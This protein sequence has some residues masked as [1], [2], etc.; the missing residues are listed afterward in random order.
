M[1]TEY[2]ENLLKWLTQRFEPVEEIEPGNPPVFLSSETHTNNLLDYIE[3]YTT[4]N[5]FDIV[6][7]KVIPAKDIKGFTTGNY[8]LFLT[9]Y[10]KSVLILTD[11]LYNPIQTIDTMISNGTEVDIPDL[12]DAIEDDNGNIIAIQRSTPKVLFFNNPYVKSLNQSNY[13]LIR[14][15]TYTI[16]N[17]FGVYIGYGVE[18]HKAIGRS[19]YA[20]VGTDNS[21]N[22]KI[23]ELKINVGT[24]DELTVYS[25]TVPTAYRAEPGQS[26]VYWD[27]EDKLNATIPYVVILGTG[28]IGDKVKYSEYTTVSDS[29]TLSYSVKAEL[30][31]LSA[32]RIDG[33]SIVY[34]S[35]I[36]QYVYLATYTNLVASVNIY[37]IK[38]G[39]VDTIYLDHADIGDNFDIEYFGGLYKQGESIM[40]YTKTIGQ[41]GHSGKDFWK[42]GGIFNENIQIP[43]E[44]DLDHSDNWLQSIVCSNVFN[45][46]TNGIQIGNELYYFNFI[47]NLQNYNGSQYVANDYFIPQYIN[48]YKGLDELVY[49]RNLYSLTHNEGT[50]VSTVEIPYIMLN[51]EP[52]TIEELKGNDNNTMILSTKEFQKNIYE[53]VMVNF[54]YTI[55]GVDKNTPGVNILCDNFGKQVVKYMFEKNSF[56]GGINAIGIFTRDNGI[57][58]THYY[59]IDSEDFADGDTDLQAILTKPFYVP[60]N[61]QAVL[62]I[63]NYFANDS[64]YY[65]LI[66]I[67]ISNLE[68]RKI[69]TL[70]QIVEVE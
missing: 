70:E 51:D 30:P 53:Q 21:F 43:K 28:S 5:D 10:D 50:V 64:H 32:S 25:G 66:N 2:K 3:D 47:Y 54:I 68:K 9:S 35:S 33:I 12:H 60:N 41:D 46:Y 16:G 14:K 8:I 37:R 69:Y 18:I 22:P 57:M 4:E 49:S 27:S 48:L 15:Y 34:S 29:T 59:R 63:G 20:F 11:E 26:N 24:S 45:L 61:D 52:I 44:F 31:D 6:K 67:D 36:L 1:T 42:I 39:D 58:R 13:K 19:L 56:K 65:E 7:W 17:D 62:S 55:I 40:F 23:A 38:N